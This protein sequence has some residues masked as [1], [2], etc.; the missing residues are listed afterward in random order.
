LVV[1][2]Q[3]T[4]LQA[5]VEV[6]NALV[7]FLKAQQ[8]VKSLAESA[9]AAEQSLELVR[10]QYDAG[11]T[12]FNRVLNVEQSLNLQQDLLAVAQGSVA[13][14]LALL[15]K[16]LGG[17]WQIRLNDPA[18]TPDVANGAT[19]EPVPAA[20]PAPA[21]VPT[22]PSAPAP[23]PPAQTKRSSNPPSDGT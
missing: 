1:Q 6:E 23:M 20:N 5:N 10:S 3:N 22:P 15:Y 21:A 7:G 14:N 4:V 2:Y 13:T 18:A 12:D 9:A 19:G 17:G 8:A 16:A 11:K